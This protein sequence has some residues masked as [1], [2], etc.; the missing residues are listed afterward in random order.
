MGLTFGDLDLLSGMGLAVQSQQ[1]DELA[2]DEYVSMAA[3]L[4]KAFPN[5]PKAVLLKDLGIPNHDELAA[6]MDAGPMGMA[7]QKIKQSGLVNDET[8][9][10]IKNIVSMSDKDYHHAFGTG[11]P[12]ADA[13]RNR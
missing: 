13:G 8:L 2:R 4:A 1:L 3:E 6:Q 12:L 5:F 11:N 9:Q 10:T 7:L